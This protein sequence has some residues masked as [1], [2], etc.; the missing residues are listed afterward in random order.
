M[1]LQLFSHLVGAEEFENDFYF[2]DFCPSYYE[3]IGDFA[4]AGDA[5]GLCSP[6]ITD[7]T[8]RLTCQPGRSCCKMQNGLPSGYLCK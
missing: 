8:A 7:P 3:A 1:P 4:A 5:T 6:N 2:Y